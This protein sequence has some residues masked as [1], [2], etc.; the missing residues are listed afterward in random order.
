MP[1]QNREQKTTT[2]QQWVAFGRTQLN[3]FAFKERPAKG[4]AS[5]PLE[6]LCA[7]FDPTLTKEF[8]GRLQAQ[9]GYACSL[10]AKVGYWG[11]WLV[12]SYPSL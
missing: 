11:V 7:A 10:K 2:K 4:N 9:R 8:I 3:G 6:P 5:F 1:G 12:E